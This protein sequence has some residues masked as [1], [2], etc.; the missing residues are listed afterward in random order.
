[1]DLLPAGALVV[2]Y[3]IGSID[4][5][6]IVSRMNGVD[7][8]SIGSGNPGFSNVLR[9]VGKLPAVMVLTGDVLKGMIAAAI[10][11]AFIGGPVWGW[12]CGF[13]AVL[14]HCYPIFHRFRGGKG[15][16]TGA[17][18]GLLMMPVATLILSAIYFLIARVSK[19]ASVA[20]LTVVILA[21]PAA[22]LSGYRGWSLVWLSASL[23]L[24]TFRHWS[25]IRRLAT[26]TER[27]V[28]Q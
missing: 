15:V 24:I 5:A 23:V 27:K 16:A 22:F 9:S 8:R 21:I 13:V 1:M 3:V 4:F 11:F 19:I 7:I 12:A 14:G 2:C 10:G 28:V 25:N 20:S 6:V 17:G 26:Q 18:V